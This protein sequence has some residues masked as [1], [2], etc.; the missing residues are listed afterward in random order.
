MKV[1][2]TKHFEEKLRN[3][4]SKTEIILV[5]E[6]VKELENI[7]DSKEL[8][9][10]FRLKRNLNNDDIYI[11]KINKLLRIFLSIGKDKIGTNI[12]L[13]ISISNKEYMSNEILLNYFNEPSI[14]ILLNRLKKIVDLLDQSL[15]SYT[16][17]CNAVHEVKYYRRDANIPLS[18]Y[19]ELVEVINEINDDFGDRL[20]PQVKANITDIINLLEFDGA[21][22]KLAYFNGERYV[23]DLITEHNSED[24]DESVE[25][26]TQLSYE[27]L[28]E[29][30]NQAQASIESLFMLLNQ[31]V[32]L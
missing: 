9:S 3:L 4:K 29:L 8:K 7:N 1:L 30:A 25:Q 26:A 17:S 20:P 19:E 27:K 16:D 10:K 21:I 31:I 32:E 14:D 15:Y 11:Y 12:I 22:G 2:V 5:Y 28:E 13:L 24:L 18:L 6:F 23:L